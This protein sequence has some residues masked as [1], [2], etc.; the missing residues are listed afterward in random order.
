[1]AWT[2]D[3]LDHGDDW[4]GDLKQEFEQ[5]GNSSELPFFVGRSTVSLLCEPIYSFAMTAAFLNNQPWGGTTKHEGYQTV[6]A[7]YSNDLARTHN[8]LGLTLGV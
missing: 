6:T 1:M 4:L 3:D 2:D 8:L 7:R 5:H